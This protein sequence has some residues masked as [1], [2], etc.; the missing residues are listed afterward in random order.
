[1][2]HKS[3]KLKIKLLPPKRYRTGP[4]ADIACPPLVLGPVPDAASRLV[5]SI[6]TVENL[7]NSAE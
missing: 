7:N 5:H 4:T 6:V 2:N 3:A 1:M